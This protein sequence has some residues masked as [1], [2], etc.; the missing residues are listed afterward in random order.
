MYLG[1]R[2]VV[3]LGILM[4]FAALFLAAYVAH[5]V[6]REHDPCSTSWMTTT[7]CITTIFTLGTAVLSVGRWQSVALTTLLAWSEVESPLHTVTQLGA[8]VKWKED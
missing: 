3:K 1:S 2:A 8:R 6:F 5:G 4:S 7:F